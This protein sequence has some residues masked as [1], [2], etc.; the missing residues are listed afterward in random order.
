MPARSVRIGNAS[1]VLTFDVLRTID[2]GASK[3]ARAVPGRAGDGARDGGETCISRLAPYV[4]ARNDGDGMP[5]AL[6]LPHQHGTWLEA[7]WAI[8]PRLVASGEIVAKLT[9]FATSPP[10]ACSWMCQQRNRA[11]RS[12]A[13]AGG[14]GD[15]NVARHRVRS[16][17]R[18][19]TR[20]PDL[21]RR[22]RSRMIG[23]PCPSRRLATR[24]SFSLR[25]DISFTTMR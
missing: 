4:A 3:E 15:R 20:C 18:P 11:M 14:G 22:H 13:K 5:L 12:L 8:H 9:V 23:E 10:M 6:I 17:S 24:L 21:D 25:R 7:P 2:G 1:M 19:V 16:S